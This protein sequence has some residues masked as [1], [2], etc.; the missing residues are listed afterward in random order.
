MQREIPDVFYPEYNRFLNTLRYTG[1]GINALG[2]VAGS[3]LGKRTYDYMVRSTPTELYGSNAG[4]VAGMEYERS[5]ASYSGPID[6]DVNAQYIAAV[7]HTKSRYG[8][9]RKRNLKNA[10]YEI[11]KDDATVYSRFQSFANNGFAEGLGTYP[12]SYVKRNSQKSLFPAYA[13][14]LT[15]LPES[16]WYKPPG[17]VPLSTTINPVVGY[18]LVATKPA[19]NTPA[20]YSWSAFD[21]DARQANPG[22]NGV[23]GVFHITETAGGAV[24]GAAQSFRGFR[25]QYSDIK[26]TFY[27]QTALPCTYR[28]YLCKWKMEYPAW[29][30]SDVLSVQGVLPIYSHN[31]SDGSEKQLQVTSMWDKYWSGKLLHPHNTQ[32]TETGN[33][34]P[35][36]VL[37]EEKFYIPARDGDDRPIIRTLKKFFFQNDR[38]YK[39]LNERVTATTNALTVGTYDYY[40]DKEPSGAAILQPEDE[41]WLM[42]TCDQYKTREADIVDSSSPTFDLVI[43]NKHTYQPSDLENG[44]ND[45]VVKP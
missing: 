14:R 34:L 18:R 8:R 24:G 44:F 41:V 42:V 17:S 19:L 6:Q 28:V 45:S 40:Q 26:M 20:V 22:G 5:N 21:H 4:S 7:R 25:H 1:Y 29:P 15:S 11:K 9:K 10:W 27:P 12:L 2:S 31:Q 30:F 43:Q 13:F 23:K 3:Y 38:Q 35:F 37:R 39:M 16:L 36:T 33:E 32:K